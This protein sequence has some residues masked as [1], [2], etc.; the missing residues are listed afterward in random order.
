MIKLKS[1]SVKT[2]QGP[3]LQLNEDG[4]EID[5]LNKLFLLFDGFG[6]SGVGDKSVQL[7]KETIKN[8][9]TKVGNDPDATL[10]FYFSPK[11]LIEGNALINAMYYAHNLLKTENKE[12][13]MSARGGASAV[14]VAFAENILTFAATGNCQALLFRRGNITTVTYPDIL[15]VDYMNYLHTCPMSGFGLFN[16]LHLQIREVKVQEGDLVLLMTDGAYA[17]LTSKELKHLILEANLSAKERIE[18]I[19]ALANERGNIDNQSAV[20]LQF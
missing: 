2:D 13:E 16:D 1:Y 6:G 7:L 17:R 19:F 8:F 3:Y 18:R 14:G 4:L 5:L 9:Y 20:L 10:P 11:Y 15:S 12:K